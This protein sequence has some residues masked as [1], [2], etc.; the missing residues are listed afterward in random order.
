MSA[1]DTAKRAAAE[2][3]IRFVESESIIGVG[4]GSTVALFLDALASTASR[5]SKA[6]STSDDTDVRLQRLGI[7]VVDSRPS[8]FR[9]ACTSTEQTRST[10]RGERS[11]AAAV[12]IHARRQWRGPREPGYVSW[13]TP[14]SSHH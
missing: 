6:V 8:R 10:G 2:A 12:L 1:E 7:E 4:T 9:S 14:R 5:P 3:A 11:R 13:M